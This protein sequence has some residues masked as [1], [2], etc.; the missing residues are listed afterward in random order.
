M[1]LILCHQYQ[2]LPFERIQRLQASRIPKL[3][4]G[5]F[6][7]STLGQCHLCL[8]R[9]QVRSRPFIAVLRLC[10]LLSGSDNAPA[11][12]KAVDSL[13]SLPKLSVDSDVNRDE[14]LH[15]TRASIDYLRRANLLDQEGRALNL[16]GLASHLYFE[17]SST[18]LRQSSRPL[19]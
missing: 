10:N 18:S 17:G 5:S 19:S 4:G 16:F 7:T 3:T 12:V 6:I 11:A 13:F 1:G 9:V 8:T 14:M 2:G 15:F